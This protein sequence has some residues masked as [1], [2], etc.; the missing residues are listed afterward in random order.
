VP[1]STIPHFYPLCCNVLEIDDDDDDDNGSIPAFWHKTAA[2]AEQP[3]WG[4]GAM[5]KMT[6]SNSIQ[7]QNYLENN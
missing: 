6:V 1:T 5:F 3:A 7:P 2:P 4:N